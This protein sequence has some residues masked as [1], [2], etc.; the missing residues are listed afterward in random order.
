MDTGE[1][2]VIGLKEIMY[3]GSYLEGMEFI[4]KLKEL[5]VKMYQRYRSISDGKTPS[6]DEY[7]NKIIDKKGGYDF[8]KEYWFRAELNRL[9]PGWSW[10]N[11]SYQ[12][13]GTEY[14][15]GQGTLRI[16]DENLLLFGIIPPYR[17][18]NGSAGH[19]ITYEKDQPHHIDNIIDMDN[20]LKIV[21]SKCFKIAIQKLTGLGDDIYRKRLDPELAGTVEDLVLKTNSSRHFNTWLRENGISYDRCWAVLS[22]ELGIRVA[23]L[24][25]IPDFGDAVE[26]LKGARPRS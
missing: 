13:I 22:Q 24:A 6:H 14:I 11:F 26:I 12:V 25:D 21:N 16:I 4:D 7:G 17:E 19:R 1:D 18:C 10:I 8:I 3:K 5:K 15:L 9:F 20:D 23:S 2:I